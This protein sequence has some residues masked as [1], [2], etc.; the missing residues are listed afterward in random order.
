MPR[1]P[2][3]TISRLSFLWK[4]SIVQKWVTLFAVMHSHLSLRSILRSCPARYKNFGRTT[5]PLLDIVRNHEK[6]RIPKFQNHRLTA[7]FARVNLQ[8]R[9]FWK[10]IHFFG[11]TSICP[12]IYPFFRKNIHLS[13]D[14]SLNWSVGWWVSYSVRSF[15]CESVGQLVHKRARL[16]ISLTLTNL[17]NSCNC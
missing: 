14:L 2:L 7:T 11:K 6:M 1:K 17:H 8:F 10:N 12:A 5:S 13:S 15:I 3:V 16:P 4:E 9:I